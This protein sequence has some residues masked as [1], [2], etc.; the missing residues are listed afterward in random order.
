MEIAGFPRSSYY[1]HKSKL[2]ETEPEETALKKQLYALYHQH[3]RRYGYRRL[4]LALKQA[5]YLINHKKTLRLMKTLELKGLSSPKRRYSSY[6]G[7]VG[8]SADNLLARQFNAVRPNQKWVTDVT[9]FKVK[10]EKLYLSP[11]CDLY[12]KEIIA[13]HLTTKPTYEMIEQMLMGSV[14]RLRTEETPI[15]HSDRGW[16]YKMKAYLETLQAHHITRSMSAKGNC[17]DNAAMESFFGTLK[18]E[19]FYATKFNHIKELEAAI[20]EY[21]AYYNNERIKVKLGGLSPVQYRLKHY[22]T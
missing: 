12:N 8:S 1:Y 2:V 19:L 6:H 7:A 9:E 10:E 11:I 4:T 13:Y 14:K 18:T 16:Q 17:L 15:L 20:H 5:G 22:P 21:I 3:H